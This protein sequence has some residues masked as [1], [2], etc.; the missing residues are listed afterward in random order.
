M[1]ENE[2]EYNGKTYVTAPEPE[3]CCV[4]CD[5]LSACGPDGIEGIPECQSH[6]RVDNRDV[7]FVEKQPCE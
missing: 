1:N 7:I 4:D 2:F 6:K 5:L 3:G